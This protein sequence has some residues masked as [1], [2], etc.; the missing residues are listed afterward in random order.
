MRLWLRVICNTTRDMTPSLVL[1]FE[2]TVML[3]INLCDGFQRQASVAKLKFIHCNELFFTEANVDA[4]NGLIGFYCS[5][6]NAGKFASGFKCNIYGPKGIKRFS[7]NVSF[8]DHMLMVWTFKEFECSNIECTANKAV[9]MIPILLKAEGRNDAVSYIIDPV[10]F[11][12]KFKG[13]EAKQMG[14]SVAQIKELI[15]GKNVTLNE[16]TITPESMFNTSIK[17]TGALVLCVPHFDYIPSLF[18]NKEL[19]SKHSDIGLVYHIAPYEVLSNTD[20]ID[21]VGKIAYKAMHVMDCKELNDD[22]APRYYS[23]IELKALHQCNSRLFPDF[24]LKPL[25]IKD[26]KK[27]EI[28]VDEY[29]KRGVGV[30]FSELGRDYDFWP[31]FDVSKQS[32]LP[33][34][35]QPLVEEEK[36]V[37]A[38]S[39]TINSSEKLKAI[40]KLCETVVATRKFHNEPFIAVL[41][42]A[43]QNP[44]KYRCV[45][46]IYM[47]IPGSLEGKVP[48]SNTK[49]YFSNSFG[50]ILDAGEGSY[51]QIVDHFSD[52]EIVDCIIENLQCIFISHHHTDHMLGIAKLIKES[53]LVIIKKYGK[54]IAKTKP[55]YVIIPDNMKIMMVDLLEMGAILLSERLRVIISE[56]ISADTGA[57]YVKAN[58]NPIPQKEFSK[59]EA[60]KMVEELYKS[61][62]AKI[63]EMW[64]YFGKMMCIKRF[65][66]YQTNHCSGSHGVFI[67]GKDWKIAYTGDTFP[68]L[69]VQNFTRNVD[70]LIHECTFSDDM[71]R[72]DDDIR[73]TSLAQCIGIY[74]KISPWRMLLTHFSNKTK[75]IV[76]VSDEHLKR[77]IIIS[78][79]H[80]QFHLSDAE[81][82]SQLHPLLEA[83][84]SNDG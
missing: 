27:R 54:E 66:T 57:Y 46:S 3:I 64:D 58:K 63:K 6:I 68:C 24:P 2:N 41:G 81:W 77:N 17:P 43:A 61:D 72:M 44:L 4:A 35:H 25:H 45:S 18:T 13:K 14:L 33:G 23:Q 32:C 51:G 52:M 22:T 62:N 84:I 38:V 60:E 16:T 12:P 83:L 65:H 53:D 56:S 74:D 49:E 10:A 21:F 9:K 28:L 7:E 76:N 37:K 15:A 47:N 55:L 26:E 30:M 69:T 39:G 29:K 71:K 1:M 70:L 50:I 40:H 36:A 5:A 34:F 73:H 79:D 75:K 42:T 67:E 11:P 20:Y 59:E 80:L 19:L 78:F 31:K 48:R 8:N 82:A